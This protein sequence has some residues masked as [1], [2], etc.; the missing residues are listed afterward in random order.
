M[1]HARFAFLQQLELV[2]AN[3]DCFACGDTIPGL[4][5]RLPCGH[6]FHEECLWELSVSS[7]ACPV[8]KGRIG[9][10]PEGSAP[11]V[12]GEELREFLD[13]VI[14]DHERIEG[15]AEELAELLDM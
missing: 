11:L 9:A 12:P 15:A 7:T 1:D 2:P 3:S 14:D 10:L 13:S 8:C 4:G 6:E 5:L